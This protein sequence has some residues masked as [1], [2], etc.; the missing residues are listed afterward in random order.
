MIR[1]SIVFPLFPG[2][3][4]DKTDLR[5]QPDAVGP[6]NGLLHP[7]DQFPHVG[8]GGRGRPKKI[9]KK[10]KFGVDSLANI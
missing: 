9:V 5:L 10:L 8:T 4:A 1:I 2:L 3:F 6:V 7:A